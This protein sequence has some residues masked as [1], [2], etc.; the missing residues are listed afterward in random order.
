ML[1]LPMAGEQ[2]M[3]EVKRGGTT[4]PLHR[5]DVRLDQEAGLVEVLARLGVRDGDQPDF[6][7]LVRLP[8]RLQGAEPGSLLSPC[9]QGVAELFIRVEVVV[10]DCAQIRSSVRRSAVRCRKA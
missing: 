10:R 1:V 9:A 7:A 8:D 5:V 3:D 4:G 6:A 2:A